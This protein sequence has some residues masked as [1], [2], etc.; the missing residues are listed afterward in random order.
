MSESNKANCNELF[1]S[2][3]S[4]GECV[5]CLSPDRQVVGEENPIYLLLDMNVSAVKCLFF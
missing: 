3:G 1:F 5:V 2:P 4:G